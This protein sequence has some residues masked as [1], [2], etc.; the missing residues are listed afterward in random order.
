MD[1]RMAQIQAEYSFQV[2][3]KI[4]ISRFK[5]WYFIS[6]VQTSVMKTEDIGLDSDN[7]EWGLEIINQSKEKQI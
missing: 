1:K 2:F 6:S 5:L 3:F 4:C 7:K